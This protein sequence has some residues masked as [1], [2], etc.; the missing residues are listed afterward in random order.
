MLKTLLDLQDLDLR[1]HAC[2]KR[3]QE[4]PKQKSKF[5]TR[6]QR[7]AEELT[8]SEEQVKRLQVEQ[9]TL[10]TEI[11]KNLEQ[12]KKWEGQLATVKKND[13]YQALLHEIAGLKR[14]NDEIEEKV[15]AL[16]YEIEEA[17]GKL[18]D[19]KQRIAE[20]T[21]SIEDEC[22]QIDQELEEAKTERKQLEEQRQ[23]MLAQ[24]DPSMLS[25]YERILRRHAGTRV[26]VPLVNGVC[27]GCHMSA[28][29]QVVNEILEG[30]VHA[31]AH[32]GRLLYDKEALAQVH[33]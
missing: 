1:I 8:A 23:A 16:E 2:Q 11:D 26:I 31:C 25:K 17:K 20:E 24:C 21:Q 30:K 13:E 10:Q 27:T 14:K 15:I 29:A 19:D 3:E 32:C 18:A 22:K 5:D 33:T 4:I 28:R 9:G 12:A 6:R 7:L